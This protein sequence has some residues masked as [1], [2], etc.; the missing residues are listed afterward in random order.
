MPSC[1]RSHNPGVHVGKRTTADAWRPSAA[2]RGYG[3]KWQAARLG[4]LRAHPLCV[5]CLAIGLTVASVEV[6]HIIPHRGDMELFWR[7]GNWAALCKPHHSRKTYLEDG[8]CGRT[9]KEHHGRSP[10]AQ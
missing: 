8:G 2:K 4:Y 5:E 3:R 9:R 6:D 7:P 10:Q 1:P